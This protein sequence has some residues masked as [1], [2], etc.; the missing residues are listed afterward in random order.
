[1][2]GKLKSPGGGGEI[3][4]VFDNL[5]AMSWPASRRSGEFKRQPFWVL[6]GFWV[7]LVRDAAARGGRM[8]V[9]SLV[10]VSVVQGGDGEAALP[11]VALP[12]FGEPELHNTLLLWL[13][14]EL[15]SLKC[16]D[17]VID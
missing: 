13:S 8:C 10:R 16:D 4:N 11:L 3:T 15:E 7:S 5:R 12:R 17:R 9:V 1:M 6:L 14:K 2:P